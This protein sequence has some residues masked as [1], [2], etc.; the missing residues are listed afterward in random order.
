MV[1]TATFIANHRKAIQLAGLLVLLAFA[2]NSF[3]Q[4]GISLEKRTAEKVED[5]KMITDY[6]QN[7]ITRIMGSGR[8]NNLEGA[9][10][11]IT[12]MAGEKGVSVVL[13]RSDG[14]E[15]FADAQTA[16]HVLAL[17]VDAWEYGDKTFLADM[18]VTEV[19]KEAE[20]VLKRDRP[21]DSKSIFED[22]MLEHDR[23][24][25]EDAL[26]FGESEDT[27]HPDI[28]EKFIK[29][30]REECGDVCHMG[31]NAIIKMVVDQVKIE[32]ALAVELE[33]RVAKIA[34]F[35]SGL[36]LLIWLFGKLEEINRQE[37]EQEREKYLT[38]LE[39]ANN[40]LKNLT[41]ELSRKNKEI[42]KY[43][44]K[45]ELLAEERSNQLIHADRMA[46]LGIMSAGVAHEINN[47]N[48]VI[49]S[50]AELLKIFWER[51]MKGA[52]ER[53]MEEGTG[54][55]KKITSIFN[56]M[57]KLISS[58]AEGSLRISKIVDGLKDFSRQKESSFE[59][60]QIAHCIKEALKFSK[61]DATLKNEVKIDL[62]LSEDLP[63]IKLS[64]QEMEQVFINLF[65]NAAHAM[66][67]NKD[68][69]LSISTHQTEKDIVAV[70]SDN[71]KGMD[72]ET[73]N[74]I[75]APFFTTHMQTG[76][77][78]LGLAICY[79]VIEKHNGSIEVK[80]HLGEGTTFTIRLPKKQIHSQ[81]SES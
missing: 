52:V 21:E 81:G 69:R 56:D 65:T 68:A 71:G 17:A 50:Y 57:P 29:I 8:F 79:G 64:L 61:F 13:Y 12:E 10:K 16:S 54:D 55:T 75:F 39:D 36:L 37:R 30:N 70:I 66:E 40:K 76:G 59:L 19:I 72:K 9:F 22:P 46:T 35:V 34:A 32:K 25:F 2:V 47:P 27:T 41:G 28:K 48:A 31:E 77:T 51:Q 20:E 73:L 7:K 42:T 1:T 23:K 80:S 14:R 4:F 3:R 62:D 78:G 60:I 6:I 5:A 58:I 45:M 43:A 53:A 67:G 11:K 63:A 18:S 38:E 49:R 15:A 44:T 74:K 24:N 26:K 33:W